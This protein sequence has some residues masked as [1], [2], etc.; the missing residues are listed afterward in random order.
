[1]TGLKKDE[2]ISCALFGLFVSVDEADLD[3]GRL[4]GDDP[5]GE[6]RGQARPADTVPTGRRKRRAQAEVRNTKGT[7]RVRSPRGKRGTA[8]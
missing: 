8:R 4:L 5:P 3:V 1:M 2:L 7:D 6:Q